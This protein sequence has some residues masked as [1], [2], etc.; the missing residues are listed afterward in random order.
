MW[1]KRA[2]VEAMQTWAFL[3]LEAETVSVGL[4][5]PTCAGE[6]ARLPFHSARTGMSWRVWSISGSG[7]SLELAI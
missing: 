4:V 6:D 7:S 2:C 3:F 1:E 5:I